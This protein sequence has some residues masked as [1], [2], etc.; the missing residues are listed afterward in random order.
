MGVTRREFRVRLRSDRVGH[1][2]VMDWLDEME[3]N[4]RGIAGLQEQIIAALAE[5]AKHRTDSPR[6][7]AS[8]E[9][10][11]ETPRTAGPTAD[12]LLIAAQRLEF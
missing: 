7:D 3:R 8:A 2:A 5:H 6:A 1:Q 11:I 9:R 4:G 10:R 12:P